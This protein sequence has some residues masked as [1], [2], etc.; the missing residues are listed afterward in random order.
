M[1]GSFDRLTILKQINYHIA[2][3]INILFSMVSQWRCAT[4]HRSVR[5]GNALEAERPCPTN[6]PAQTRRETNWTSC[7]FWMGISL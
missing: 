4:R 7:P 6:H 2:H 3:T 5:I 1:S